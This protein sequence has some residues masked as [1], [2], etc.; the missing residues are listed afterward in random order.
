VVEGNRFA[1]AGVPPD[2]NTSSGLSLRTP[3]NIVRRNEFYFCDGPGMGISTLTG[4]WDANDN[5]VYH[6]VLY[7]NGYPQLP[8]V[9]TW[10]EAGLLVARHGSGTVT[11]DLAIKNNVFHDNKTHGIMFYYVDETPFD[12]AGN[13][14][15]AGPPGFAD[16]ESPVT[17]RDPTV[18]DFR[19]LPDSPCIDAGVF[20]TH[21][22]ATGSG[23][24]IPVEDAGFFS[25]GRG[26]V[27]PDEVQLEGQS[28]R[29]RIVSI[30]YAANIIVVDR[31]LAFREGQGVSQPYEGQAPDIGAHEFAQAFTRLHVPV[32][33]G[34]SHEQ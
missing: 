10:K 32:A 13:W 5:H 15:E 20:L 2:Q 9:E 24:E 19:L 3:H 17:P 33:F 26:I 18:P 28:T 30:D 25:D 1:F 11:E 21:V 12:I 7:H 23:S 31:E 14:L 6:N 22:T 8:G 27:E 16:V 29:A 34:R 4:L